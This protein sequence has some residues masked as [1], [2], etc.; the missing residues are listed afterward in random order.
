MIIIERDDAIAEILHFCMRDAGFD[1]LRFSDIPEFN[2]INWQ[3]VALVLIDHYPGLS[4][5]AM[6]SAKVKGILRADPIPVM[7]LS[8]NFKLPEISRLAQADDYLEKPFDLD[9][10]MAKV[11]TLTAIK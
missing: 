9:V 4:T 5:T 10:L 7:L 8:T 1:P 11:R 3:E 2:Q 6:F